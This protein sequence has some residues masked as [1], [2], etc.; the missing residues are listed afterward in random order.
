M[1]AYR[2]LTTSLMRTIYQAASRNR[3]P[4]SQE[5][6]QDVFHPLSS[7][8]ESH[9]N[10][11]VA[12]REVDFSSRTVHLLYIAVKNH[13]VFRQIFVIT[14]VGKSGRDFIVWYVNRVESIQVEAYFNVE[15]I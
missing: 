12:K 4:F 6:F 8:S 3:G 15:P 1:G 13:D 7:I 11:V 14:I 10:D 9:C 5:T 2:D